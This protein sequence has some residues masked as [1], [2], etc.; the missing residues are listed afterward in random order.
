VP[1]P[2]PVIARAAGAHQ[3]GVRRALGPAI[4]LA[5]GA[6]RA[7]AVI[8]SV[9]HHGPGSAAAGAGGGPDAGGP[10]P[11]G[12]PGADASL[13]GAAGVGA[14][15]GGATGDGA[16]GGD[17]AGARLAV[18]GCSRD[19]WCWSS[20]TP[21]GN[22]LR[23]VWG[24]T[25]TDVWAVG[26]SG[27]IVHWNGAAWATSASGSTADLR[28]VWGSGARDVWAVG[29]AGAIVHW[30]GAAWSRVSP[31]ALAGLAAWGVWGT[32]PTDLWIVGSLAPP[33]AP[34]EGA[35]F[36]FDGAAW[37]R[38]A[39]GSAIAPRAISGTGPADVWVFGASSGI[40]HW[41]GTAWTGVAPASTREGLALWP[42][43]PNDVWFSALSGG[44]SRWRGAGVAADAT[45]GG[46]VDGLWGSGADDVWAVG[47]ADPAGTG[48]RRQGAIHHWDGT[49]WSSMPEPSGQVLRAAWGSGAD[50]VWAVGDAGTIVHWNGAAW[51]L[52]TGA[53]S[54]DLRGLWSNGA[55]DVW[56]VGA[57]AGGALAQHWDGRAWTE[58][59]IVDR[60]ALVNG[61][62]GPVILVGVWGTGRDD[63]WAVGL[64]GSAALVVH[65]DGR[66]WS[67]ATSLDESAGPAAL[68]S[69]W[70]SAPDDVWAAGVRVDGLMNG[71]G[72]AFHFDGATWRDVPLP[73]P[74][75]GR[76]Y[77][78]TDVWS[79]AAD[80]VWFATV[81]GQIL[82]WDG[83]AWSVPFSDPG[84]SLYSL[85]GSGRDDVWAAG[86]R[87]DAPG[88]PTLA[89]HWNGSA[90][91]EIA[92]ATEVLAGVWAAS[93]TEA[94]VVGQSGATARW[95]GTSVTVLDAGTRQ[96]FAG[97][98]GSGPDDV[99]AVTTAGTVLHHDRRF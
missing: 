69:V 39:A 18:G 60:S 98:W 50:D 21:Q 34:A 76:P 13:E 99:W 42:A 72:A 53:G 7:D 47:D 20:P 22:A 14:S 52:A 24:A 54:V 40:L 89:F 32:G 6:C 78:I 1:T 96:A 87:L 49:A 71:S 90:W 80:D 44:L 92:V 48:A 5:L 70:G 67:K 15:N 95:D 93:A 35:I 86:A 45:L 41:N 55:D 79:R 59:P 85:F 17:G 84:A 56:A 16:A 27:A 75:G 31:P 83:A 91:R 74:A 58:H 51:S 30:D 73:A 38:A 57:R 81:S 26:E 11:S 12:A 61:D 94:W 9:E 82:R 3:R 37:S 29:D 46:D 63:V 62:G 36:H 4:L 2:R 10:G 66:A 65:W 77:P 8:F 33:G 43:A 64:A 68:S 25:A 97:V 28:G 88:R 19:G 23:A